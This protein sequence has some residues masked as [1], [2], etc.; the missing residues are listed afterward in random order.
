MELDQDRDR[1]RALVGTVKKLPSLSETKFHAFIV[2]HIPIVEPWI[3]PA[4]KLRVGMAHITNIRLSSFNKP[5]IT[6]ALDGT[7]D[8][9]L[10]D[11]SELYCPDLTLRLLM[12]HICGVSK[13]FGE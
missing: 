12:S 6:H 4:M 9:I 8:D 7:E 10:W 11:N 1:W 3:F 13:K 5:P 2:T